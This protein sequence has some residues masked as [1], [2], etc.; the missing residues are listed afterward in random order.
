[1]CVCVFVF[2]V[3][4]RVYVARVWSKNVVHASSCALC[5]VC[6]CVCECVCMC[7]CM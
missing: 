6:V 2:S 1:M 3:C 5:S 7:V 4:V